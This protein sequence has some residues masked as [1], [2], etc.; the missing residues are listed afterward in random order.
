MNI[1]KWII[2]T[3]LLALLLGPPAAAYE[4]D[5]IVAVVN[6]DVIVQSELDQEIIIILAQLEDRGT[7]LPPRD[8]IE[9]QV[10]ER[11]INRRLQL[12]AAERLGIQVDDA[13]LARAIGNIASKN[14][15][16]L[17][18]LRDTLESEGVSFAKFREDTRTQIL[19]A[20]LNAQE[21]INRIT[22]TD[23]EVDGFLARNLGRLS[24][25]SEVHLQHILI[26]TPEGASPEVI[27]RARDK[28]QDLVEQLRGGADF[29]ETALIHSAG[30][31]ALEGGDLGWMKLSQVPTLAADAARTLEQGE[32]SDPVRSASGFHIFRM[33]EYKG[34][35]RQ[36]ITQTHARHILIKTNELVSDQDARTRLEQLRIR[37][38]GGEDFASIARS[39]SD[40]TASAI[41][42]GDLAWLSP[43]DTV[44][45]FE[46]ELD[47]LA[48]GEISEPF[49]SPFGWHLVQV[50]ERRVYD[51]TEDMLKA[52]AR[53]SIR[54]RKA[55]EATELWLRRLRDEA[56]VEI[57]LG[58]E[59]L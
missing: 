39:H 49:R 53:D 25:R 44:P 7:R 13:T 18:E 41:K 58:E 55:D 46:E 27:Q 42:G 52:K 9:R 37:L 29:A 10:L 50:L 2:L 20:R 8:V 32:I 57:K 19:L 48:P 3:G 4:L 51:N 38:I 14:N 1:V 35:D 56:Y 33:A 26:A 24:E 47:A 30:R 21:V 5:R 15:M 6:E 12:Q 59:R 43:G 40:D 22:V 45:I 17:Q 36:V 23:Q 11:M 16:T 34:G 31:Q 54:E 28:A